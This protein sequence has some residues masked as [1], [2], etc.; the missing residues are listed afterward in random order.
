MFS[1][2]FILANSLRRSFLRS[3]RGA[4]LGAPV[5]RTVLRAQGPADQS[6]RMRGSGFDPKR[7]TPLNAYHLRFSTEACN[8]LMFAP[9]A[10]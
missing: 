10:L 3:S 9:C 5:G 6:T 8:W 2:S 7:T 4:A 1:A